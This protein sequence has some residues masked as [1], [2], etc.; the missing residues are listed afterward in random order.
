M[1]KIYLDLEANN[2]EIISIGAVDEEGNEYY[3]LVKPHSKLENHIIAITHIHEEDVAEA[4]IIDDVINS[5]MEY[6]GNEP[7]EFLT[8][9]KDTIFLNKTKEFVAR[10][11]TAVILKEI[12]S[13]CKDISHSIASH[14]ERQAIGLFSAY[15]TMNQI[16]DEDVRQTH[17]ALD[18]AKLLKW[19][20][21]N[22][23]DYYCTNEEDIIQVSSPFHKKKKKK[24]SAANQK[25]IPVKFT[26]LT[27]LSTKAKWLKQIYPEFQDK[28]FSEPIVVQRKNKKPYIEPNWFVATR[29]FYKKQH[30]PS[31]AGE[32]Y[33]RL[34]WIEQYID[35]GKAFKNGIKF[36]S[37]LERIS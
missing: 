12:A 20:N 33:D 32:F 29:L 14:F 9:G 17:N 37:S 1:K 2:D 13:R 18:D 36:Y 10:P 35:S 27:R 15:L 6:C 19:V 26:K 5:F 31:T 22:I 7:V 16:R 4:D 24:T 23:A 25:K 11:E 30:A 8:Y 3:S 28:C 34:K 21:E